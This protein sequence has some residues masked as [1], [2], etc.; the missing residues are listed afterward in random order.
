M[1]ND[2]TF[3]SIEKAA[4]L[5]RERRISAREL[6]EAHLSAIE[7]NDEKIGA[8]LTVCKETALMAAEDAD[9]APASGGAYSLRG[10]P[11]ALKDNICTRSIRTTCASRMLSDFIPP[12]NAFVVELL[13]R[14]SAV[15]LGKTNMD[16]FSMGSFCENSAFMTTRNPLSFDRVPG[17]SSGGSAAAVASG[18]AMFALGSD[19]GGS[20][21]LPAAFCGI[22]GMMPTYGAISRNGLIAFASSIDRIGPLTRTVKDNATVFSLL[23]KKDY[24]DSTSVGVDNNDMLS[25]IEDGVSGMRFAIPREMLSE[26]V[27]E[28]IRSAVL[29]AAETLKK[30]GA[31]IDTISLPC[32][33]KALSAY[34]IISSAEASSNL[35]RYDGVRYGY[36]SVSSDSTEAFYKKNRS[37]AFGDEVKRRIILGTHVLSEDQKNSYYCA[38][39]SAREHVKREFE[40]AFD[41]FDAL[42]APVYPKL[43]PLIGEVSPKD[44]CVYKNDA[45]TVPASIA[46][47]PSVTLPCGVCEGLPVGIQIMGKQFSERKLYRIAYALERERNPHDE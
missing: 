21:R 38:A 39:M 46:G 8:Y 16:E 47:I 44:E 15:M 6:T 30:L 3:L 26:D 41:R 20:V 29:N 37:E 35:A 2:L 13:N 33:E 42:L 27:S 17:G 14:E 23:A 5:L 1:K 28:E 25:G 4:R 32:I 45:L 19:T 31:H 36:R 9:S 22:V 24:G 18:M 34:Y 10:I 40:K 12:Y 11:Y 43:P 7:E